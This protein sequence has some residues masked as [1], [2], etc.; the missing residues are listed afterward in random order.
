MDSLMAAVS[1]RIENA[2]F[3]ANLGHRPETVLGEEEDSL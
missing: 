2:R 3:R 1:M